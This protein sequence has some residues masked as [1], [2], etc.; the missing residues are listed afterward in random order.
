MSEPKPKLIII[1]VNWNRKAL[2]SRCL[3]SLKLH[4][5]FPYEVVVV[6]NGSTD[7][8]CEL[9]KKEFP[10]ARVI[11]N[12]ENVGF[13]R[14]NNQALNY[15]RDAGLKANY[16]L[17]LNNDVVIKDDS[18]QKLIDFMDEEPKVMASCPAVFIAEN[19]PQVG[20]GGFEPTTYHVFN[21]AFF[22]S[23][24][25]P[26]YF[27]GIFINQP[28]YLKRQR[29]R[30]Q[31]RKWRRVQVRPVV[32]PVEVDWV[33]GVCL[34]SRFSLWEKVA[35]WPEISFMYAEDIAL[36]KE[37]RK[38]GKVVYFPG[39]KV[40]HVKEVRDTPGVRWLES[41]EFY[42]RKG[43]GAGRWKIFLAKMMLWLGYE[44]RAL[45]YWLKPR[46]RQER[47]YS[48]QVVKEA[49]SYLR[50]SL[51]SISNSNCLGRRKAK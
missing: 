32:R 42:L 12:K 20:V 36:G 28:Y 25:F 33:S 6:D 50:A 48:F 3:H 40:Y 13:A 35:G 9:L 29:G 30:V 38:W 18:L 10:E 21:Y 15:L 41:L 27:P 7:G 49:C 34:L 1:V 2:L 23:R 46:W 4:L 24:L 11:E 47:A 19:L 37:I 26:P 16:V 8:S 17:F 5:R 43:L 39:A 51:C 31:V 14:A 45:G 44:L 22:L